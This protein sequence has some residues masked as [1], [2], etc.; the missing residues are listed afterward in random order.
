MSVV[1]IIRRGEK[2]SDIM[3]EAKSLTFETGNE[4]ALVKLANGE[5][6]LV[7]GGPGGIDLAEGQITRLYGHTHP[8]QFNACGASAADR[9]AVRSLGQRSSWI[10]ERGQR[11]KFGR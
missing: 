4:Y 2:L 5:R 8:Y 6:A 11:I 1:R 10:L 9:A 7:S 3:N